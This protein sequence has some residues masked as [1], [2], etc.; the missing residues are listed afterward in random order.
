LKDWAAPVE[1]DKDKGYR[2]LFGEGQAPWKAIFDAAENTGGAEYYL[3]EQEGSR[4]P[5]LETAKKCLE[6]YHT[7]RG[8]VK[9]AA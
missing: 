6:S 4:Y 1:G 7:L 9:R 5:A 8:D 2:V 3:I